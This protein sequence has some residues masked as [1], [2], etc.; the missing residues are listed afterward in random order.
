MPRNQSLCEEQKI[1]LNIL[2]CAQ[3][4]QQTKNFRSQPILRFLIYYSRFPLK[5]KINCKL[6]WN[7]IWSC[8]LNLTLITIT[9]YSPKTSITWKY[10]LYLKSESSAETPRTMCIE[11]L[12]KSQLQ[13]TH[14]L[15]LTNSAF[16]NQMNVLSRTYQFVKLFFSSSYFNVS[17]PFYSLLLQNFSNYY[18]IFC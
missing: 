14:F 7:P 13:L 10:F 15:C 6:K 18:D 2:F 8:L 11:E 1:M 3:F 4:L 5:L 9:N 17:N 16:I 12:I